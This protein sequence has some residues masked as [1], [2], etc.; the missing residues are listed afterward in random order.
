MIE[1]FTLTQGT[2]QSPARTVASDVYLSEP[3]DVYFG[4]TAPGIAYY[5]KSGSNLVVTLLDGQEVVIHDFFV[6]GEDGSYSRLLD[7]A[8]GAVEVTGLIAPEPFV[9]QDDAPMV[10]DDSGAET[11]AEPQVA[12]DDGA[13][14][15]VDDST[16]ASAAPVRTIGG[17]GVDRLIFA[18]FQIPAMVRIASP[19]DDDD[20]EQANTTMTEE[21]AALV[22]SVTDNDTE[23]SEEDQESLA[24]GEPGAPLDDSANAE[25]TGNSH[26]LGD[27]LQSVL[28]DLQHIIAVV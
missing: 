15:Q 7:G 25:E 23:A 17:I 26:G 13:E 11:E 19:N 8:G 24:S 14:Q 1:I 4:T 20:V 27:V 5:E 9:P 12:A 16:A 3:S 18:A 22:L 21:D 2:G 6:M 28:D 10:A